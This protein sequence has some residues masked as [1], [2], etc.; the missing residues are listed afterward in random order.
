MPAAWRNS[1]IVIEDVPDTLR[2]KAPGKCRSTSMEL[3]G[4]IRFLLS[5]GE[6]SHA[7]LLVRHPGRASTH[8]AS[9]LPSVSIKKIRK[10]VR[11]LSPG[12]GTLHRV[13]IR[14]PCPRGKHVLRTAAY[15]EVMTEA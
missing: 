8:S 4:V 10:G 7:R 13:A 14:L 11:C 9:G 1:P 2:G 3:I 6:G 15:G 12:P 5:L